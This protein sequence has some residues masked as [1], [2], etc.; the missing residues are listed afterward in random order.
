[1]LRV[2]QSDV[3]RI[4]AVLQTQPLSDQM[5]PGGVRVR[6]LRV[7]GEGEMTDWITFLCGVI[8]IVCATYLYYGYLK[9]KDESDRRVRAVRRAMDYALCIDNILTGATMPEDKRKRLQTCL[10]Y[11]LAA[12]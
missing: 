7:R 12:I 5:G 1:M 4:D 3:A 8:A 11:Y 6:K 9:L 10:H 2:R